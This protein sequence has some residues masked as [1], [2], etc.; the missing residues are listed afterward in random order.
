[1]DR[2]APAEV[3]RN[4]AAVEARMP[5]AAVEAEAVAALAGLRPDAV[6]A[7]SLAWLLITGGAGPPSCALSG[8]APDGR[9][10]SPARARP[11]SQRQNST[12]TPRP[13][14]VRIRAR[15]P[16]GSASTGEA[17]IATRRPRRSMISA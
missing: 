8:T 11:A 10:P 4:P 17:A 15:L 14:R 6:G 7:T 16:L 13:A 12:A 5:T 9:I 1:G 3:L 2:A